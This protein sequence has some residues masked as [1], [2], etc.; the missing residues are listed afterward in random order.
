MR[1]TRFV[2]VEPQI[3]GGPSEEKMKWELTAKTSCASEC[4]AATIDSPSSKE[5][6]LT[7]S[8]D[9]LRMARLASA[10]RHGPPL[11]EAAK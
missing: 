3:P 10:R 9:L 6:V 11:A 2:K 4:A 7:E 5:V 1:R 8:V